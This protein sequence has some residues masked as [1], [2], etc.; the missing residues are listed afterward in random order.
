MFGRLRRFIFKLRQ[1]KVVHHSRIDAPQSCERIMVAIQTKAAR[2]TAF[3]N[4]KLNA[5]FGE[6]ALIEE[7]VRRAQLVEFRAHH[8]ERSLG[9]NAAKQDHDVYAPFFCRSAA[10][11]ASSNGS[12]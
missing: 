6:P 12:P 11:S 2:H 1:E 7:N 10:A 9:R 8:R 5:R 3:N 4:A